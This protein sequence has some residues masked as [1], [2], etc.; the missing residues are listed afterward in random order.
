MVHPLVHTVV[1]GAQLP[2]WGKYIAELNSIRSESINFQASSKECGFFGVKLSTRVASQGTQILHCMGIGSVARK[3]W[4]VHKRKRVPYVLHLGDDDV[5]YVLEN[6]AQ[7][8]SSPWLRV[9]FG[10]CS[11]VIISRLQDVDAVASFRGALL[12]LGVTYPPPVAAL[13]VDGYIK[14]CETAA[15]F[16]RTSVSGQ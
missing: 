2:E 14:K 16:V 15:A 6:L 8:K 10:D 1:F 11:A 7:E 12:S 9:L 5:A 4:F 13:R 3:V